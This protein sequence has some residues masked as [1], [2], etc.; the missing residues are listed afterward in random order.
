ML[1]KSWLYW[2]TFIGL[3]FELIGSFLLTTE[4]IGEKNLERISDFLKKNR[5]LN[6]V[7]FVCISVI[8]VLISKF[9]PVL[10]LTEALIITLSIGLF[11]D[12]AP[13]SISLIMT[14][15]KRGTAGLTGFII[16]AI[17]FSMQAYVSLIVLRYNL[18]SNI[19][20]DTVNS[21]NG[22]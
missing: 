19:C 7:I 18:F 13:K 22:F 3:Y 1:T 14:H 2:F 4:A 10:S 11:I 20:Y 15:L 5:I 8:V 16:F 21:N 9:Y 17:G 12:F 6:F